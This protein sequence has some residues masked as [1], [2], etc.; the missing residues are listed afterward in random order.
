[1]PYLDPKRLPLTLS[2]KS[3]FIGATTIHRGTLGGLGIAGT[4]TV[5]GGTIAPGNYPAMLPPVGHPSR[6][7]SNRLH[8]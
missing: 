2:G 7:R 3:A 6:S 1:M 4:I 8:P 5:T